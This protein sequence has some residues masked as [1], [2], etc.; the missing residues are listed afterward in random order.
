DSILRKANEKLVELTL[1]TQREA[2]Q[3]QAQAMSLKQAATTLQVQNKELRA[4]A[5]TDSLT[6]LANRGTFDDF[7]AASFASIGKAGKCMSLVMVDIDHFKKINDAHGHQAG[8]AVL[9]SLGGLL[10]GRLRKG[11]LGA[12]YGGEEFALV[13]PDATRAQAAALAEALRLMVA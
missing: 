12:R 11:D 10:G 4:K 1:N 9:K 2:A 7:F 6:G 3:L 8:D 5:T 13:L